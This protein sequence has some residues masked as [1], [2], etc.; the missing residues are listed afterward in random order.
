MLSFIPIPTVKKSVHYPHIKELS[1]NM[2]FTLH[3]YR[4]F[5]KTDLTIA[6]NDEYEQLNFAS[7]KKGDYEQ[8]LETNPLGLMDNINNKIKWKYSGNCDY[9]IMANL[10]KQL[11]L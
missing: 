8:K 5:K 4:T 2:Q 11:Y 10:S 7:K 9:Q 1:V 6:T 3:D